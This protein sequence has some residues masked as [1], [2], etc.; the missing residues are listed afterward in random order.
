MHFNLERLGGCMLTINCNIHL[1]AWFSNRS[2]TEGLDFII[3]HL[4]RAYISTLRDLLLRK[5]KVTYSIRID[6]MS[7]FYFAKQVQFGKKTMV[8]AYKEQIE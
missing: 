2:Q 8:A 1:F 5:K 7:S 4:E 6:V 3:F